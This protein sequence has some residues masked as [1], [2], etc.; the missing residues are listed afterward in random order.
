[1][2]PKSYTLSRVSGLGFKEPKTHT[3]LKCAGVPTEEVKK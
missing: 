1:M 3:W 2:L